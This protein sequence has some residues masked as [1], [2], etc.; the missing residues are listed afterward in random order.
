VHYNSWYDFYSYQDEGFNGGFKDPWP[1]ETLISSLRP[2]KMSE[3]RCIQRIDA[4][5]EEMVLKRHTKLDRS[6]GA[7]RHLFRGDRIGCFH[8]SS[9]LRLFTQVCWWF[10]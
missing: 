9:V 10:S 5:G 4:F 7:R 3:G 2:D 1:N 6:Y 8:N